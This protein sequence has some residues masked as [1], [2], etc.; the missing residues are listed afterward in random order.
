VASRR[1]AYR[2]MIKSLALTVAHNLSSDG[3]PPG[4]TA[5]DVHIVFFDAQDYLC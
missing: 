1:Q 5:D 3:V 2:L 4:L